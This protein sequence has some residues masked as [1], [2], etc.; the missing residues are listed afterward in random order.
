MRNTMPLRWIE[1]AEARQVLSMALFDATPRPTRCRMHREAAARWLGRMRAWLAPASPIG[2]PLLQA[3][4]ALI[5]RPRRRHYHAGGDD[6]GYSCS[7]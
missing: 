5:R 3:Q 6:D 4:P 2:W 1:Q 7:W